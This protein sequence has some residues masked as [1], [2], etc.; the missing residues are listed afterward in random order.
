MSIGGKLGCLAGAVS[1]LSGCILVTADEPAPRPVTVERERPV[2]ASA[3]VAVEVDPMG[4]AFIEWAIVGDEDPIKCA[5][6]GAENLR[7]EV[8]NE[9][10]E[11]VLDTD[12]PCA[13]FVLVV[14]LNP[15]RYEF[16]A[17][18]E[19]DQQ[20]PL[21]L[22]LLNSVRISLN[23]DIVVDLNFALEDIF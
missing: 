11:L 19:D 6:I 7:L 5:L 8:F 23:S 18:I 14:E 16:I 10:D 20:E 13:D 12:S 4:V 21:S 17:T 22:S 3:P 1:L 2:D 9:Q 15:G